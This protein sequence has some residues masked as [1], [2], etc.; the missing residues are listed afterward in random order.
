VEEPHVF[1]GLPTRGRIGPDDAH[2]KIDQVTVIQSR[3]LGRGNAVRIMAC[4]TRDSVLQ[5]PAVAG[6]TLIAENA[7]STVAAVTEFVGR[8]AFRR[9]IGGLVPAGQQVRID[10]PVRPLGSR[11]AVG[12]M[13][14]RAG[15][16]CRHGHRR[17]KA[18]DV[19]IHARR[20]NRVERGPRRF[21]FETGVGLGNLSGDTRR[22]TFRTIGMAFEADLVAELG[23]GRR[24]AGDGNARG[25][26]HGAGDCRS[27]RGSMLR[28]VGIVAIHTFHV[29]RCGGGNLPGV[30]NPRYRRT[31]CRL[32]L[33]MSAR[34]SVLATSPL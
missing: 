4:R 22:R 20:R 19:R 16:A 1:K 2:V 31:L 25:T 13:A 11:R 29:H 10:G 32:S 5:V 7:V 15:D 14:I 6:K 34:R 12:A 8:T 28:G 9:E 30:V 17:D 27:L 33:S 23:I 21:E 26:L 24:R 3:S 18:R